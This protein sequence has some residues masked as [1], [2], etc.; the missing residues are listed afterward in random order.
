MNQ[1]TFHPEFQE[2]CLASMWR[3]SRLL[4]VL[5]Q[6]KFK[7]G[8]LQDPTCSHLASI[9]QGYFGKYAK[10]PSRES[11]FELI[12]KSYPDINDPKHTAERSTLERKVDDLYE[13]DISDF[14]FIR[15]KIGKF[16]QWRA[17]IQTV[18]KTVDIIKTGE[19]PE[20]VVDWFSEAIKQ[21]AFDIKVGTPARK[22]IT[23]IIRQEV[24]T[25]YK[26][27]RPTGLTHFDHEIGGGLRGGEL[28]CLLAPP[29]GFKSGTLLNFAFHGLK[30]GVGTSKKVLY[31]TLELSEELQ[32]LRF[33]IRTTMLPKEQMFIDTDNYIKTFHDRAD[34]IFD[35]D[36]EL[37]IAY[38]AP[39]VCT[40]QT[41]RS[42]LDQMK[43]EGVEFDSIMLDYLDLMGSDVKSDKDY[44]EKVRICTDLRAIAVDYNLPI[45]TACRATREATGKKRISMSHMAGAFERVAICDLVVALCQTDQERV[46][47]VM[48]LVPVACRNDGGNRQVICR[49]EP[50]RMAIWS[51]EARDLTDDD[52]DEE[53]DAPYKKKSGG[54][55]PRKKKESD[56][57]EDDEAIAAGLKK[58]NALREKRKSVTSGRVSI[59]DELLGS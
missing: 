59:E 5:G 25:D 18:H 52:F 42:Y 54:G 17:I 35:D 40:P 41:I 39:Y 55:G 56:S 12:R 27:R 49:F 7:P 53:D 1:T 16:M 57:G 13:M 38:F 30:R 48:R 44:L 43:T 45:W 36:A 33:A 21:G 34:V 3:D 51:V 26:P 50:S 11:L 19:V 23:K 20:E 47:N 29:K 37:Y 32:S 22:E 28:G 9:I 31:L 6:D 46:S 10:S 58:L 2:A 4:P 14:E 8:F 24:S 15:D